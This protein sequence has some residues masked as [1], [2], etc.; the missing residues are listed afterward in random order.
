MTDVPIQISLKK[1]ENV[2]AQVAGKGS[3][4]AP[5]MEGQAAEQ[6]SLGPGIGS[7]TM[8]LS[9]WTGIFYLCSSAQLPSADS[10]SPKEEK[11]DHWKP[12]MHSHLSNLGEILTC[13]VWIPP[14]PCV[15]AL[16]LAGLWT[17][18]PLG[19]G[20]GLSTGT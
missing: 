2:T 6:G 16:R 7:Y 17:C 19:L 15:Q 4:L 14:C 11:R 20:L 3:G 8:R 10:L 9:S 1:N 13:L 12:E 5:G 18:P